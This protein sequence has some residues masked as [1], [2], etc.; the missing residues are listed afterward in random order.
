MG[1]RAG[2]EVFSNG[3]KGQDVDNDVRDHGGKC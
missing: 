2:M 1:Q 3:T